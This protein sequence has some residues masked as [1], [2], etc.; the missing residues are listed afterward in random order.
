MKGIKFNIQHE[1]SLRTFS[2]PAAVL[3]AGGDSVSQADTTPDLTELA[4]KDYTAME[5]VK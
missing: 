5:I 4:I 2:V 3:G 1:H